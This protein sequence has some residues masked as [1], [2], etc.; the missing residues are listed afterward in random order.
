LVIRTGS[1]QVSDNLRVR[2]NH[3]NNST[4]ESVYSEVLTAK[5]GV[6]GRLYESELYGNYY[7]VII[8]NQTT[9]DSI[10]KRMYLKETVGSVAGIESIE[11]TEIQV[12]ERGRRAYDHNSISFA[13]RDV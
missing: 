5:N 8:T 3:Y 13:N 6:T 12:L 9:V 1:A 2:I 4:S 10:I 7:Q 11:K